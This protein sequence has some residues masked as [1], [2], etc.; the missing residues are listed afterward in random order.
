MSFTHKA[1]INK[2]L[3]QRSDEI[4]VE[5]Q[6][7]VGTAHTDMALEYD[8]NPA[9]GVTTLGWAAT[10]VGDD[11]G[12]LRRF[13]GITHNDSTPHNFQFDGTDDYLGSSSNET[14]YGG[15][16]IG[17]YAEQAWG[18]CQWFKYNNVNHYAFYLTPYHETDPDV[19]HL[20]LEI[21]TSD[22]KAKL[23]IKSDEYFT[24][25]SLFSLRPH[26]LAVKIG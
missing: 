8:L 18:M 1:G 11:S 7:Y 23:V 21:L 6:P 12:G 4:Y 26:I 2:T 13:N 19:E 5:S 22:D 10:S 24:I 15:Y 16:T 17:V 3:G 9:S 20:S 25:F 14:S